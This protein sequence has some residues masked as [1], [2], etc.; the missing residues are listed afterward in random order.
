MSYQSHNPRRR[1]LCVNL[2]NLR[3]AC[4]NANRFEPQITQTS[5]EKTQVPKSGNA[6]GPL[7]YWNR[8]VTTAPHVPSLMWFSRGI[9]LLFLL[10]VSVCARTAASQE[11]AP[12]YDSDILP[13]L[14]NQCFE[15]HGPDEDTRQADLRLDTR[16][17]VFS[18]VDDNAVVQPGDP[19]AS[20]LFRRITS[21]DDDRMPP[22]D[23]HKRLTDTQIKAIESWIENGASWKQHWSLVPPDRSRVPAIDAPGATNAID[24]FVRNRLRQHGLRPSPE[25]DKQTLIRRVTIDLTGLP[26]T[27]AAIDAFL[28]DDSPAAYDRLVDRLLA[29]P[30]FGE[31][32]AV[33]WLDAARYADT[34][35]Y[36][37]DTERS[38]WRWRDWVIKALNDNQPFDQ[39]TIEQLAGDLLPSPTTAQQIAT[40]FNRNHLINNEAGAIPAEY[41]VENIVDRVNTTATVWMGLSLACCQ[42]HD[43]KYD[44]FTQR[45]YYQLYAFFNTLPE[46]GLDGLNANAKPLLKAPTALDLD[47]LASLKNSVADAEQ[48]MQSLGPKIEAGQTAWEDSFTKETTAAAKGLVGHWPLDNA[49]D[50]ANQTDPPT[51][52]E[53]A[54]AAYGPG[55][56]G[57][58][59]SLEGLAYLNAADRFNF[60]ASDSFSIAV[61]VRPNTK[62]GRLSVVSRMQNAEQLFRGY[63]LQLV[64]GLPAFFLIHSFPDDM[65]QVQ[66]KTA[67]EPDQWHHLTVTYD[68]SGKAA[69]VKLYLNGEFQKPG[70][71]I[72]KL[73]SPITTK[74]P[75]WIGNGHPG[76][77]FKGLIDELR[78]YQRPLAAEDIQQLPGLSIQSLLAIDPDQRNDEQARRVRRF[79]LQ[80]HAPPTWRKPFESLDQFK[81]QLVIRERSIPTV[82]VMKE[83][84]KKR[85]THVLM[86][87][88]YN[89]PGDKVAPATPAALPAFDSEWP[90]NRLGLARWLTDPRHPLTAR[91]T[92][93]RFWQLYFG[94]GLVTTS[95]DFGV[96]GQRPSHPELL[97]WLAREFI[98]SGWDVKSLH[99]L[100]VTSATYRQS[101]KVTPRLRGDDPQ[102]RLLARGPRH[103]LTAEQI[104][105]QALS[106]S[107]LLV[108]TIGGPS[109]RPYQ[110][111]GLWREVAFDFSGAN[112]TAQIYK[113]DTG[114]KL[115]RRS[116]Y[117]F[118]KRTAPPPAMLLF[119]APDRERCVVQRVQTST[120]LQA[121]VLMND[122][123]FIEA[124]RK[125]AERIMNEIDAGPSERIVRAFR[126]ATGR[127]PS[128][129]EV[130]WLL[131]LYK[132]QHQRF[133]DNPSLS[134]QLLEVGASQPQSDL[135][136]EQLAALT[137][138]ANVI[139]N[140]DETI[141]TR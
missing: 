84:A 33:P 121:L 131:K 83:A 114:A 7:R 42:C 104:R 26:P 112:L 10:S 124:S 82:M 68:G 87:G 50:D 115:Y 27:P 52:F 119:N 73:A 32:M 69:G 109:V 80:H 29:S 30:R 45:E 19:S 54:E 110:L 48:R 77:K 65:I 127:R 113:P 16:S 63:A 51:V 22:A 59:A 89:H 58:G 12:D 118:W 15:C 38:M 85:E 56:L 107:G 5:A 41:L 64:A 76:A 3:L 132:R 125:L 9:A 139:L 62:T 103:R 35:G 24:L 4:S 100:I 140:L 49:C 66:G 1:I 101:S 129:Q 74:S 57:Q 14:A 79:Y 88:A 60:A 141:S 78:V 6:P 37:F 128:Q 117:T 40:G 2:R 21:R 123:T 97:N 46:L 36:L 96:Q 122:P 11:R 18:K 98:E 28:A 61:W 55:I 94:Q 23:T 135:N 81:Q 134:K 126:L 75:F 71:V 130:Q 25:A 99:K 120:P 86:R 72:D 136:P 34:H 137:I 13:I 102:N 39:F 133:V 20:E 106:V 90:K 44:P 92:V 67:L 43:H 95:E 105:D 31:R 8:F 47:D 116:L 70:I 111:E 53:A 108:G 17:G 91:V 93:N 138:V